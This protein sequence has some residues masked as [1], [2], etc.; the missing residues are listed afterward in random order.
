M[1][2]ILCPKCGSNQVTADKKGFS[3]KK[4][5]AGAILTGG[6]GLLAGTL[7]SNKVK[8]TCL[9]CGNEFK[10]GQGATSQTDF[11]EKKKSEKQG[12][13]G[14]LVLVGILAVIGLFSKMCSSDN[15]TKTKTLTTQ[16]QA[17]VDRMTDSIIN[18]SKYLNSLEADFII[19][20]TTQFKEL[21]NSGS[22][23]DEIKKQASSLT[24][25]FLKEQNNQLKEWYGEIISVDMFKEKEL[26]FAI[27][28]KE[29]D[30]VGTKTIIKNGQ[31]HTLNCGITIEATQGV[32][33]KYGYK[34]VKRQGELYEKIRNMKEGDK[35]I[36]SAKIINATDNT[37][38]TG[39][40]LSTLFQ[41]QLTDIR[42]Q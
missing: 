6:I 9:S 32:S 37:E 11:K 40:N 21:I 16:E 36:F 19:K 13:M 15:D 39:L 5:V 18:P 2:E 38:A 41:I 10:P 26:D 31:D 33:K 42:K 14:C 8:I 30:I 23:A 17:Q 3:G 1:S 29:R 25:S 4:A 24:Q 22:S 12:T 35:V 34:G 20:K 28:I 27:T 7:G